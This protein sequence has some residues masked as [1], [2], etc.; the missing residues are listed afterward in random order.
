MKHYAIPVVKATER[1]ETKRPTRSNCSALRAPD[2]GRRAVEAPDSHGNAS[3]GEMLFHLV[4]RDCVVEALFDTESE[5][6][7]L[8]ARHEAHAG[9]RVDFAEVDPR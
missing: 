6:E 5:A 7:A 2:G 9:H 3:A 1:P 4:C 8:E